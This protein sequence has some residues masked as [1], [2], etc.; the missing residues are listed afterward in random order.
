MYPFQRLTHFRLILLGAAVALPSHGHPGDPSSEDPI[1][2]ENIVVTA[3][4]LPRN[5]AELVSAT[6]VQT[7]RALQIKRQPTLGDMLAGEVGM[8]STAFGP[9]ASRP[10]IRG[11]GGDRIRILENGVG[12]FDA[13][14]T[15][16]DH[17]VSVEPYLVKRIEVVR[18]PASL[19]YGSSA[20]GGVV[21]VIT[22]RIETEMP[23]D[24]LSGAV[25]VSY[26]TASNQKS[27]GGV[28]DI[29]L[30]RTSKSAVVL[31]LDG[32]RRR[33]GDL[34]I[35]GYA[36]SARL[37]AEEHAHEHEEDE[38]EHDH[39]EPVRGRLPNS[40]LTAD[41]GAAGLSWVSPTASFGVAWSGFNSNY[42][43]PGH[44]HTH[45]EEEHAEE[46]DDDDH[47]DHTEEG[48]VRIDLRQR[49][50][51]AQG[52]VRHETGVL[53]ALRFKLGHAEY[54]HQ[55]LEDGNVGTTFANRGWELRAEALHRDLLGF[56]GA[57]GVQSS[58][59]D[60]SAVGEEA[61]LPPTRTQSQA[62]FLSEE[63][64]RGAFAWQWGARYE[65]QEIEVKNTAVDRSDRLLSLSTGAV[66]RFAEPYAL[67]VSVSRTER[68]PNA[69]ELYSDGPHI[70]TNAYEVGDDSLGE[71]RSL[72]WE[73]SL[74]RTA[75]FV[76]GSA[77][78][79]VNRFSGYIYERSTGEEDDGLP[80][81]AYSQQD[82]D[83]WGAELEAIFHLHAGPRHQFDL[84]VAGDFTRAETDTGENLPRIPPLKGIVGVEYLVDGWVLGAEVQRLARQN[85]VAP[86]ETPGDASTL[87]SAYLAYRATVGRVTTD[88]F[89]RG[90]NLLNEEI[91]PHTSFLK[92]VAPLAGR[93]LSAG[94][95]LAF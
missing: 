37:R 5:Q 79:Y 78:F 17:A 7:G 72:G 16:P 30:Y 93:G 76:T 12:T 95:Q 36:E 14:V 1:H 56:E 62:V 18:G 15:S 40:S 84:R 4:P 66:W 3:A 92:D 81:Y 57:L 54:R 6:T 35:P 33:A 52:E 45:E 82:A 61:F 94:V 48:P 11:L 80:V 38:D 59:N 22:H 43:V 53:S 60:F 74:R 44:A 21:N 49:R 65:R 2:L 34:E 83:F 8:A 69:Q 25:D 64:K 89:L 63:A 75:G 86:N 27:I 41:G 46:D 19:L 87:L 67:A 71:E 31:H 70:G 51:D 24:F 13:S 26:G 20:V 23:E 29:A 9:G 42:G 55:E 47:H 91:R 68:A 28:T 85:R 90:T 77:S 32:V 10:I 73:A 88:W 39:E 50:L 58:R